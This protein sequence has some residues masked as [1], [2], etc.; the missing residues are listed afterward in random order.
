MAGRPRRRRAS[1]TSTVASP[2][3]THYKRR[4]KESAVLKPAPRDIPD[5]EWPCYV[6]TEAT[7]YRRL[8]D[9]KTLVLANP[10]LVHVEG[11]LVVHG[12][13][14]V[15]EDKLLPNLVQR[16]V[17]AAYI[18][19]PYSDRYSIGDGP[20]VL[21]VSG[22]AGW[23]EIRPSARYQ[24]MYDQIR[25]AITLYY[26]AFEVYDE[27]NELRR[28]RKKGQ[29]LSPPTLDQI[30]LK[31]AVRAGDG[32]V[33]DEVEALCHKWA[34]FLIAHFAKE[35]ELDWNTT[36][37]AKWLREAHPDIQKRITD[38]ANGLLPPPP[39]PPPPEAEQWDESETLR[40]RRSRSA[41]TSSRNSD[42]R[43]PPPKPLAKEKPKIKETPVPL[44][45]K[46]RQQLVQPASSKASPAPPQ[47]PRDVPVDASTPVPEPD[48][49]VER[50]VAVLEDIRKDLDISKAEP[51]KVH[52]AMFFICKVRQYA[53]PKEIFA[54]Y[55]KDLLPRLGPEW[56]GTPFYNSLKEAAKK[57]W[58]SDIIKAEDIPSQTLRRAKSSQKTAAL[59]TNSATQLPPSIKLKAKTK[60]ALHDDSEG[61]GDDMAWLDAAPQMRGR[62]SGKGASLRLVSTSKKRPHSELD[63]EMSGGR[64]GR[65][66]ART[67]HLASDEEEEEE[68]E[69]AEDVSDDNSGLAAAEDHK[70]G[71]RLPLPEGAVRVVVHAERIP[72]TSPSGPDGTWTCDQEGCTYVVRSADEQDAQQLIQDHFRVHEA[73]AEKINLAVKESRGHMP[74]KYAYFPPVLLL[75]RMRPGPSPNRLHGR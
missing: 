37:F 72:T 64:R 42:S 19:I 58:A 62:R 53:A 12:Y 71:S 70:A 66:S 25:E 6:L 18:E 39:P 30:F 43:S 35:V 27:Y 34:E 63:D 32:I 61:S 56:K 38:A 11:P 52:S 24:A 10:L 20:L 54:Y 40:K 8:R 55:A 41:R 74:I 33:R 67:A 5:S 4:V 3:R 48:T 57:P 51:R 47:A 1:S 22:A 21:W 9:G 26:A 23:F 17:R 36:L 46:Y 29:K 49:P 45:E 28:A 73:Q 75:V 14:E 15:D 2:D 50:L 68:L 65:K 31:Y 16:G 59:S 69:D 60:K 7:I 44:P 13:L